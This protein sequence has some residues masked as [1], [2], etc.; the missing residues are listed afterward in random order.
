MNG[1]VTQ[2]AYDA[3]AARAVARVDGLD[4]GELRDGALGLATGPSSSAA[5]VTPSASDVGTAVSSGGGRRNVTVMAGQGS[6]WSL[7]VTVHEL[8]HRS[9]RPAAVAGHRRPAE[10]SRHQEVGHF[11]I[12]S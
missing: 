2:P 8:G 9:A 6:V 10:A 11:L 12:L 4:L 3:S 1:W 7:R 5:V